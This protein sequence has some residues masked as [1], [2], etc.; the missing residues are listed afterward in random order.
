M[1][2]VKVISISGNSLLDKTMAYTAPLTIFY[3]RFYGLKVVFEAK[4][5]S[6]YEIFHCIMKVDPFQGWARLRLLAC[7]SD[8]STLTGAYFV[9]FPLHTF[10]N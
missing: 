5:D 1:E 3:A 6:Q 2:D 9:A 7:R 10:L 8:R 4:V